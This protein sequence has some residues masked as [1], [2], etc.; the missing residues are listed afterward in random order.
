MVVIILLFYIVI[1]MFCYMP[2][3]FLVVCSTVFVNKNETAEH[4][5]KNCF[6]QNNYK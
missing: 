6:L 5:E 1:L 4:Y 2:S 3:A